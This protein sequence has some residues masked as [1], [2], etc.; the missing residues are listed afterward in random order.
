MV[1]TIQPHLGEALNTVVRKNIL[2]EQSGHSFCVGGDMV[3]GKKIYRTVSKTKWPD[4]LARGLKGEGQED[5]SK[6]VQ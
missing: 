4:Q 2:N 6:E 5:Q 3:L 1:A